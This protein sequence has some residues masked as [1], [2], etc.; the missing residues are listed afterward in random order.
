MTSNNNIT[1]II[2]TR[3]V[4]LCFIKGYEQLLTMCMVGQQPGKNLLYIMMGVSDCVLA[5]DICTMNKLYHT[6]YFKQ[7]VKHY[8]H[9]IIVKK[10]AWG[11]S[12]DEKVTGRY[13]YVM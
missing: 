13:C 8:K 11:L 9:S 5:F 4:F 3:V 6:M 12:C 7:V 1:A 10:N 2:V